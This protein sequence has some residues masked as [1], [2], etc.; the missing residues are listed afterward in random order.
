MR[1][2]GSLVGVSELILR[3]ATASDSNTIAEIQLAVWRTTYGHLNP[4]MVDG[5]DL[6][7][8]ADNWAR[9]AADPTHRLRLVEHDGMVVGYAYSGPA[10]GEPEGI[11]ELHAIYLLGSAQGLG[12]GRLLA[13]DALTGLAEAGYAECILWVAE[14]NPRARGFY[15]RLGFRQDS[16]LDIWRGLPVVRYRLVTSRFAAAH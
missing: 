11:G 8:T 9:A 3:P 2:A 7:R 5:L 1:Q 13:Q 14:G 16:G 15:Q 6:T 12:A 10:G 4:A